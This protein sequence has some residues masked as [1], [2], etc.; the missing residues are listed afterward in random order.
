MVDLS[1]DL[2]ETLVLHRASLGDVGDEE[3]VF[4][5]RVLLP[6]IERANKKRVEVGLQPIPDGITNHTCR[7]TFRVA[8]LRGGRF[9]GLRDVADGAR[10]GGARARGLR[11]SDGSQARD[12]GADGRADP[13]R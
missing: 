2:R 12:W 6:L 13:G 8:A 1:P 7:R 5:S 4:P 10:V 3:L 11:E 9:A